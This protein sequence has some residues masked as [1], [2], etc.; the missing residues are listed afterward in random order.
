MCEC[1]HFV[2]LFL[3][4]SKRAFPGFN[5]VGSDLN[6]QVKIESGGGVSGRDQVP[7]EGT[8]TAH[9]KRLGRFCEQDLTGKIRLWI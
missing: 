9:E 3:K 7:A 6:S 2:L 5:E 1:E 8:A 4:Y